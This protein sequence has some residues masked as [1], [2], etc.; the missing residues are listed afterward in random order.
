LLSSRLWDKVINRLICSVV[1]DEIQDERCISIS[2]C[3]HTYSGDGGG[4]DNYLV[5][6][7]THDEKCSIALSL[8]FLLRKCSI[9]W[10]Y[11]QF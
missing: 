6:E 7:N 9:I 5:S 1:E 10:R 8:Q 4:D 11:R 3:R 2:V